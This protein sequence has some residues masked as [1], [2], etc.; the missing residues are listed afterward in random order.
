MPAATTITSGNDGEGG[1]LREVLERIVSGLHV[2]VGIGGI[3]RAR[4]LQ[5]G[6]AVRGS[7]GRTFRARVPDG[8]GDVVDDDGPAE[9]D[10]QRSRPACCR[11]RSRRLLLVTARSAVSA[12][13][14][15][16]ALRRRSRRRPQRDARS[17]S[18]RRRLSSSHRTSLKFEEG[19]ERRRARGQLRGRG[20]AASSGQRA[21]ARLS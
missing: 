4:R 16:A 5:Q 19:A 3:G 7:V 9:L 6:A 14:D 21:A 20:G 18:A 13:R 2:Q 8:A 10:V 12:L 17:C 11:C 1:E 15:R